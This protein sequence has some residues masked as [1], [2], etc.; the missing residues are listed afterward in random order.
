MAASTS[1]RLF[2]PS[3]G[4]TSCLLPRHP[5]AF[6]DFDPKRVPNHLKKVR[7]DW[8]VVFNETTPRV[9]D[10]DL[11]HTFEHK[12]VVCCVKLSHDG[13]CIATGCNRSAFVYDVASGEKICV[14]RDKNIDPG[15][16]FF[17]RGVGFSPD[18]KYLATG[19]ESSLVKVWDLQTQQIKATFAGHDREVY[20]IDF[21]IVGGRE[22]E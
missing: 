16:D 18:G 11:V 1:A 19:D 21:A 7:E 12:S 5:K 17:T 22:R 3:S 9:L 20:A 14:L 13:K 2:H 15:T 6:G 4:S 8:S 10:V